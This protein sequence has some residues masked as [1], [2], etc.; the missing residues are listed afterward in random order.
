LTSGVV[1]SFLAGDI[2]AIIVNS[3]GEKAPAL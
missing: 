2:T 1:L 3:A